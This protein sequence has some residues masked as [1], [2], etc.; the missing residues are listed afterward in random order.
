MYVSLLGVLTCEPRTKLTI[1]PI[2]KATIVKPITWD[3]TCKVINFLSALFLVTVNSGAICELFLEKRLEEKDEM[4]ERRE[5]LL[6]S[7]IWDW[8]GGLTGREG[9]E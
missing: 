9:G 4:E 8:E 7:W 2:Q 6:T 1:Y 5:G 3:K